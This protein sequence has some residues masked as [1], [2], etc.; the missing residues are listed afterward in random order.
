MAYW[1]IYTCQVIYIYYIYYIYIYYLCIYMYNLT[2]IYMP[3]CHMQRG[4]E[5]ERETEIKTE[6]ETKVNQVKKQ[7]YF[8]K[9][10]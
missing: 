7:N 2:S 9:Y 1:Y 6:T 10:R 8:L 5:K 4:R 3:I